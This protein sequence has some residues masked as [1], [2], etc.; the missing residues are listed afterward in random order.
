MELLENAFVL[1]HIKISHLKGVGIPARTLFA[2][3]LV[4]LLAFGSLQLFIATYKNLNLLSFLESLAYVIVIAYTLL[5]WI[6]TWPT[7]NR[8]L[9]KARYQETTHHM[10]EKKIG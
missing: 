1:L 5:F 2:L 10:H 6:K 7:A 8:L 4:F 9:N 3:F